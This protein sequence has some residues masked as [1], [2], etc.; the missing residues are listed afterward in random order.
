MD[1]PM[2]KM[3]QPIALPARQTTRIGLRPTRSDSVPR[4]GPAKRA[5]PAYTDVRAPTHSATCPESPS[6]VPR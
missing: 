4:I 6:T 5:H 2:P 3:I 1:P